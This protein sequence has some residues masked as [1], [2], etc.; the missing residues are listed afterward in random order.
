[1]F[2]IMLSSDINFDKVNLIS[3]GR[4]ILVDFYVH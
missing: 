1:M 4:S 3:K 2:K